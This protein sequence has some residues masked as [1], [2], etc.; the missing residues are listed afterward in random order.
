MAFV[1]P[2]LET[3]ELV[4][5]G[6]IIPSVLVGELSSGGL[7]V[8]SLLVGELSRGGLVLPS[9]L[10]GEYALT[11]DLQLPS[12]AVGDFRDDLNMSIVAFGTAAE[13]QIQFF[14][15]TTSDATNTTSS[16]AGWNADAISASVAAMATV[17][18]GGASTFVTLTSTG[19]FTTTGS[20]PTIFWE[21]VTS[22]AGSS[23]TGA[24]QRAIEATVTG[25][26]VLNGTILGSASYQVSVTSIAQ[27]LT[28]IQFIQ[29]FWDGWAYN[30]N[31]GAP[32]TYED[33]KFNSFARI[34]AN[35]YGCNEAGIHL[36]SGDTDN[37][38]AIN[39][40]VTTGKSDLSTEKV[41]GDM[42]KSVSAVYVTAKSAEPLLLT[43]RVE[44]Q[45]H[46]YTA[47]VS[48]DPMS[49]TRVTPGKGLR[50]TLW[51]L[52]LTTQNGAD[53]E[54]SAVEVMAVPSTRR[55]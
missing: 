7:H 54:I 28:G 36:L 29:D 43:C 42:I 13:A 12:L 55:I 23:T 41:S 17:I 9:L 49:T 15:S 40:V 16:L 33:F 45:E 48:K 30:L 10:T 52:E 4:H 35:Y 6:L 37:G 18:V 31:T 26:V 22:S 39:M 34:G 25:T 21:V 46:T 20:S 50:G 27:I 5:T 8:P 32:S 24:V 19:A 51:Q 1:L 47:R 53:A 44:G 3:G 38:E 2:S 14:V 11:T